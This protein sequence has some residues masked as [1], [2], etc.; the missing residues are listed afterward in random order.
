MLGGDA[1]YRRK[2]LMPRLRTLA[3]HHRADCKARAK[4]QVLQSQ[5]AAVAESPAD[6]GCTMVRLSEVQTV[7][8]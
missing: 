4:V 1:S 6:L 8:E 5:G 3:V 7:A 2:G